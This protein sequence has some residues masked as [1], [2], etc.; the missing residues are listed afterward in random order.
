MWSVI[1]PQGGRQTEDFSGA[2]RPTNL[3]Y[4]AAKQ[5]TQS[6]GKRQGQTPEVI[7]TSTHTHTHKIF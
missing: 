7:L 2:F 1:Q 6:Q 3:P 4:M 5:E